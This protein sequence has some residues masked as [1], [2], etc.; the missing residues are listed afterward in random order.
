MKDVP[1]RGERI[2]GPCVRIGAVKAKRIAVM[3]IDVNRSGLTWGIMAAGISII[4][5][6]WDDYPG[7]AILVF[8][9]LHI[10]RIREKNSRYST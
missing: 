10:R 3:S 8:Y 9:V 6:E 5:Q 7:I 2:V 1:I 4:A